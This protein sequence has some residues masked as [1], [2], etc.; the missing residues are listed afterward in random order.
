MAEEQQNT[1]KRNAGTAGHAQL[2]P[3]PLAYS[4]HNV[5]RGGE[6][7]HRHV[8]YAVF[9]DVSVPADVRGRRPRL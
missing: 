6:R 3:T 9:C 1:P 2:G 4:F 7:G 8:A 5:H